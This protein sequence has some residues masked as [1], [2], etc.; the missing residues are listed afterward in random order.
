ME[1]TF[2]SALLVVAFLAL[3]IRSL[4]FVH[5]LQLNSYRPERYSKWCKEND[6]QLIHWRS[7][8][9]AL[10]LP[11]MYLPTEY[12]Y[13]AGTVVLALTL[14][15]NRPKKAK[16]PLVFTARVK[17]LLVTLF[18]LYALIFV[19]CFFL[20]SLRCIGFA[21]LLSLLPWFWVGAVNRLLL[22]LERYISNRFVLDARRRLESMPELTVIG[23]TGSY[24]KT[25]T[26]SFL[27][28]LLSVRY[29]VL[30]TPE[31]YNT[32]MGVVRTIRER[33][34]PSHEIF[35]AEMGAKNPGDIREICDLVSPKYGII[36]SIG[37][38]HLET[39]RSI[40]NVVKTKFELAD[41]LPE[42]GCLV[43]N[44][45]NSYIATRLQEKEPACQVITYGLKDGDFT[46]TID[47][48]DTGGCTFTV[49][50]CGRSQVFTTKLLGAHNIQNLLA[51]IAM[52]VRLGIPMNE[53]VYPVR[54]LRPVEHRLQ[55]L[56]NDFI[57]DAYNS[58]PA[59]FRS[60]L[61]VLAQFDA[62]RVLVT[63]GMVELGERQEP[64]NRELGTYAADKC[65]Y[66]VLV[67][68]RQAPPLREGLLSGGFD[69]Q[70][71]FVVNTLQDGLAVLN[72]LPRAEKR[73]VL[74]EN[75]LPDNF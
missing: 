70:R 8:L 10:L 63:P 22:P 34:K 30:M 32:T 38:Q 20:S 6:S 64:L 15:L 72:A 55:L 31:S 69:E 61:D 9:P 47:R 24:G 33:M 19:L 71:L 67:G 75:D 56:P 41:V 7:L 73:I 26:K 21:A 4:H 28:A 59:G 43:A 66:A 11:I 53:L 68:E 13:A 42:N 16:K 29:N 57:D 27:H 18:L 39:F 48:I 58:N 17:R 51:C 74:L 65:D 12:A 44:A 46:A 3:S 5:M 49:T 23:I 14:V 37:E 25:S 52:A 60:A 35:I 36:T 40:D 62:Q 1:T 54:L 50:A 2:K 45:D